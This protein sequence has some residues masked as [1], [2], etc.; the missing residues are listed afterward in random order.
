MTQSIF[1]NNES[2]RENIANG[3]KKENIDDTKVREG[4]KKDNNNE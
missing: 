2:I 3:V 4:I 1:L